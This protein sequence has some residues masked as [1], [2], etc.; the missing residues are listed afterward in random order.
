MFFNRN[1]NVFIFC[2]ISFLFINT[3]AFIYPNDYSTIKVKRGNPKIYHSFPIGQCIR[4][5][6]DDFKKDVSY[7]KDTGYKQL[8]Q[9]SVEEIYL[10]DNEEIEDYKLHSEDII[11]LPNKNIKKDKLPKYR[12]CYHQKRDMDVKNFIKF[13]FFSAIIGVSTFVLTMYRKKKNMKQQYLN[14]LRLIRK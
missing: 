13:Q 2:I 12:A 9:W 3:Q 7:C 11:V 8:V 6:S 1:N 5:E 4:C 10:K 14:I